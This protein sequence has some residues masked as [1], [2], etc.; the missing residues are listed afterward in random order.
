MIITVEQFEEI[1]AEAFDALPKNIKEKMYN[2]AIMT[3]DLPTDEQL[4][5][6]GN[7]EKYSLFGLYEG[8]IQSS[9]IYVGAVLP[10]KIT[11][12]RLPIMKSCDDITA[13]KQR[14]ASTLKHE[15]AHHFGSDEKGARRATTKN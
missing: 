10:D 13:I 11:L 4:G 6:L 14:V 8:H 12:F 3:E 2:V 9:R 15:I 5:K 7:N 1:V